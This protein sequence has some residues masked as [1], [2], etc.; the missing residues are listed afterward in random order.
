MIVKVRVNDE[1]QIRRFSRSVG[2]TNI[3]DI[4]DNLDRLTKEQITD[5]VYGDRASEFIY[6]KVGNR[7]LQTEN[8][9]GTVTTTAYVY[10]GNDRLLREL[11][12]G[13]VSV[14]YSYDANGNTVSKQDASGS[15]LYD[16][17]DEG[18]L[19][20]V[21]VLD[22]NGNPQQQME[23]RYN[24]S[25]IR[26]TSKVNLQ[27]TQFLIDEVQ[28]YSQVSEEFDAS[29][30]TKSIFVYGNNL[31]QQT[32]NGFATY[33]LVDHL[34]STRLLTD[35][36]GNI[37]NE[38][39]Y[40]AFGNLVNSQTSALNQYL[41]TGEQF[42]G[43]LNGYYLRQRYYT[44]HSGRFMR[45]DSF[46][47]ELISPISLHKYLYG[48]ANPVYYTDPS[49]LASLGEFA[50]ATTILSTLVGASFGAIGGI[51]S[52]GDW[53]EILT[54]TGKG[55]LVGAASGV[56]L[57]LGGPLIGAAVSA[58]A[59]TGFWGGVLSG[60]IGGAAS[61][62]AGNLVGQGLDIATGIQEDFE[63]DSF[64]KITLLGA[65]FGGVFLRAAAPRIGQQVS[66]WSAGSSTG[67]TEGRRYW[68]QLGPIN[69]LNWQLTG[70]GSL[71]EFLKQPVYPYNNATT[72][73]VLKAE[74]LSYPDG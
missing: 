58:I 10:D 49:G 65:T 71:A 31:I 60:V 67:L 17:N 35:T 48:N 6:D 59:G 26:V 42:D 3:T 34:G 69:K 11:V 38:Y 63:I 8:V 16:W 43:N 57:G 4:G 39:D 53:N 72:V 25:G 50:A 70:R 2:S 62:A 47:G 21:I 41:Y 36:Q 29:G 12:D 20:G 37:L 30:N 40:G 18:R 7:L 15:T 22:G 14:G 68:V 52:G 13:Q 27:E 32:Q 56:T 24:Q 5:S 73:S 23:Y 74:N 46:E 51:A 55:A 45:R 44:P 33:Y 9:G 1:K 64:V 28:P 66:H 19:V 61:S 54:L